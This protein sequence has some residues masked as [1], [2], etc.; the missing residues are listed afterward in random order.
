MNTY[1]LMHSELGI[2]KQVEAMTEQQACEKAGWSPDLCYICKL[3]DK[4]LLI[5]KGVIKY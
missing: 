3:Q 5:E 2:F 1:K 4:D